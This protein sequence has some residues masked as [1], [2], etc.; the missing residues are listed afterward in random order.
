MT[1]RFVCLIVALAITATIAV[2]VRA[3]DAQFEQPV[4]I[5]AGT[6]TFAY[7]SYP[8]P[9]LQDLNGDGKREL[10]IGDLWGRLQFAERA[11]VNGKAEWEAVANMQ[12]AEGKDIKFS[13]W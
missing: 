13:N 5:T 12:T 6:K 8:S 10:V 4:E 7:V 3:D 9:V 2:D 1:N 11:S